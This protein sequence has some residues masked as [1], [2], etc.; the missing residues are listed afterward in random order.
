MKDIIQELIRI[1]KFLSDSS[2]DYLVLA[3]CPECHKNI[4]DPEDIIYVKVNG[5][6]IPHCVKC[7]EKHLERKTLDEG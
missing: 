5:K 7:G 2:E 6:D 1:S 3:V 4:T